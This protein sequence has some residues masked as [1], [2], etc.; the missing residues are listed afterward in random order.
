MILPLD[1]PRYQESPH[2]LLKS[3]EASKPEYE[4]R[5]FH[6]LVGD[7]GRHTRAKGRFGGSADVQQDEPVDHKFLL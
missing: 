5:W 3:L 1:I 6:P 4:I 7:I 2:N